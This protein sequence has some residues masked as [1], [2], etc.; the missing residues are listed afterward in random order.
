M[1]TV[2]RRS[3]PAFERNG[4]T[5]EPRAMVHLCE[6]CGVEGAMFIFYDG[7][8]MLSWCARNE[9]GAGYCAKA[10]PIPASVEA[11]EPSLF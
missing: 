5:V 4:V 11:D 1:P 9:Q 8:T 7:K 10:E 2:L 3:G 6:G